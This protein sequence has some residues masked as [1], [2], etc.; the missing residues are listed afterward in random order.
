MTPDRLHRTL[1]AADRSG[2]S[3]LSDSFGLRFSALGD[4]EAVS[5][6]WGTETHPMTSDALA[7]MGNFEPKSG[8]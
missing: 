8:S 1:A 2:G 4:N 5:L 3:A 6:T 7:H